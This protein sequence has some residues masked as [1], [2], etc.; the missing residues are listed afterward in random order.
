MS[1]LAEIVMFV[2]LSFQRTGKRHIVPL[3]NAE[4]VDGGLLREAAQR[5]ND[6]R[7]LLKI[8]DQDCVAIEV[9]YHR[10]CYNSYVRFLHKREREQATQIYTISFQK[11]CTELI[12]EKI[13]KLDKIYHM[14]QIFANFVNI[15]HET[16]GLDASNYKASRLKARLQDAYPQLVFLDLP[17]RNHSEVVFCEKFT[18]GNKFKESLSNLVEPDEDED[19]DFE[20]EVEQSQQRHN[21]NALK[22]LY[23]SALQLRQVIKECPDFATNWPPTS[24]NFTPEKTKEFVPIPLFNFLAWVLCKSDVP[25]L[26]EFVSVD[27]SDYVKLLSIAQ[28]IIY[29]THGGKKQTPKSMALSMTVRQ[30]TGSGKVIDILNRLGHC[31]SHS[32]TLRHDT[33][34]AEISLGASSIVPRDAVPSVWTTIVADNADFGEEAKMQTHITNMIMIQRDETQKENEVPEVNTK[35]S[36]RKS[37]KA[38]PSDIGNYSLGKKKS[39]SFRDVSTHISLSKASHDLPVQNSKRDDQ[40]YAVVKQQGPVG[41]SLLP[42]WTGFNTLLQPKP[43]V[44]SKISYLPII[45]ASPTEYATIK[46]ILDSCC[47]IALELQLSQIALVCDEAVYAKVQQVRWKSP[48]FMEKVIVRLGDFHVSMSFM[49]TIAKRFKDAGL[50][51]SNPSSARPN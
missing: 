6:E 13:L 29:N 28:D 16:E 21:D 49:A 38:P 32:S 47:Q 44:C 10:Q 24:I 27:D 25:S 41:Q 34:L 20:I 15:V 46:K 39:P 3:I 11:L 8:R 14:Q 37:I 26:E 48:D 12:E 33:A 17:R 40:V 5:K 42:D 2:T 45:D 1:S 23:L 22:D 18:S 9:K 35:R 36:G 43:T 31:S 51:V 50:K 7:I 30:M 19:S 4:T